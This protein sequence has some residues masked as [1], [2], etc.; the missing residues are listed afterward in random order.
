MGDLFDFSNLFYANF[1][2]S[3]CGSLFQCDMVPVAT[4]FKIGASKNGDACDEHRIEQV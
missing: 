1:F 4:T 2:C 3:G